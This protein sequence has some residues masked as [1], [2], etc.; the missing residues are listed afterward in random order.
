MTEAIGL[1]DGRRWI[2]LGAA[3]RIL[4][5]NGGT[6]RDWANRGVVKVFRTPG[7]H[8][9]FLREDV[10]ALAERGRTPDTHPQAQSEDVLLRR[11]RRRLQG[12]AVARQPW[13]VSI[14]EGGRLRMRLFGRRLLSLLIRA[15]SERRLGA[16]VREEAGLLGREY[17]QE[18]VR[19]G[20]SLENTLA[21]YIFFRSNV[22]ESASD[23]ISRPVGAL[24][25]LVLLGIAAGY[26]A[27]TNG[28]VAER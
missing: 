2:S 28:V 5:V 3:C 13:L 26:Q 16:Q 11:I 20:V 25:D 9:R 6:L 8:R 1:N 18:M 17:G 19:Q 4:D 15:Q 21:A 12:D 24:S 22:I 27:Q 23:P 10:D 7:G 14:D